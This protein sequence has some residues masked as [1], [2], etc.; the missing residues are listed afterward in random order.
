MT[1][2]NVHFKLHAYCVARDD[3]FKNYLVVVIIFRYRIQKSRKDLEPRDCSLFQ[4]RRQHGL[5]RIDLRVLRVQRREFGTRD[6]DLLSCQKCKHDPFTLFPKSCPRN[7]ESFF[8]FFWI[9]QH[10]LRRNARVLACFR[11]NESR[12]KTLFEILNL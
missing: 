3:E 10:D 4:A 9:N 12:P 6:F 2:S 8:F 1:E 5:H 11:R 7:S